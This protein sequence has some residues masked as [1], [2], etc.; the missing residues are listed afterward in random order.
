[1]VQF[2]GGDLPLWFVEGYNS[3]FFWVKVPFFVQVDLLFDA[4]IEHKIGYWFKAE[5]PTT[6][7]IQQSKVEKMKGSSY[8]PSITYCTLWC[9]D[10]F[11][12]VFPYIWLCIYTLF[13]T[14]TTPPTTP[15][16]VLH[17]ITIPFQA[18][19]DWVPYFVRT[20]PRSFSFPSLSGWSWDAQKPPEGWS[21]MCLKMRAPEKY[22]PV[23]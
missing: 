16:L 19:G 10:V 20:L 4:G 1:M 5:L 18:P 2:D 11:D 9:K 7:R 6:W 8:S 13:G 3:D 22:T 14:T 15:T 23:N 21:W 17:S 12:Y